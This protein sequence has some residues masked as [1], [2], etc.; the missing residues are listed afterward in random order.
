MQP[1]KTHVGTLRRDISLPQEIVSYEAKMQ[2]QLQSEITSALALKEVEIFNEMPDP[3]IKATNL[4]QFPA[5]DIKFCRLAMFIFTSTKQA[6]PPPHSTILS[7]SDFNLSWRRNQLLPST[8]E[9]KHTL[10]V[11]VALGERVDWRPSHCCPQLVMSCAA[12]S[13]QFQPHQYSI[14]NPFHL[15]AFCSILLHTFCVH[16][17]C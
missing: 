7:G 4:L 3:C 8:P 11:V 12:N 5:W 17:L 6:P 1:G 14:I 16:F 10:L 2:G 13:A 15:F 9:F